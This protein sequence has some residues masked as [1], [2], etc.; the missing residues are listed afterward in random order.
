MAYGYDGQWELA[1][2]DL[3]K[4]IALNPDYALAYNNR[5]WVYNEKGRYKSAIAD[6][7]KAI[8][9]APELAIAY[10]NRGHSYIEKRQHDLALADFYK[11]VELSADPL[12]INIA[13]E[14]IRKLEFLRAL[15]VI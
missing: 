14:Y 15:G 6:L 1:I 2:A 5:G 11:V 7:T 4:A 9:L 13:K 10:C 12:L 3:D 8:E